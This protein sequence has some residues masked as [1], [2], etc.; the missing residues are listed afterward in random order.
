MNT[1][2]KGV[3][4]DVRVVVIVKKIVPEQIRLAEENSAVMKSMDE[5]TDILSFSPLLQKIYSEMAI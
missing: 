5:V 2:T 3:G 1:L 4:N